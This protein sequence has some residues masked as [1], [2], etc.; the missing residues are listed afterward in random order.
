MFSGIDS[1]RIAKILTDL[2]INKTFRRRAGD[3]VLQQHVATRHTTLQRDAAQR[4][5]A[6]VLGFRDPAFTRF[7]EDEDH[8][9]TPSTPLEMS[10]PSFVAS[11]DETHT[12]YMQILEGAIREAVDNGKNKER[13]VVA[14]QR[15]STCRAMCANVPQV[16]TQ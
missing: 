9:E 1:P 10:A 4:G 3:Q 13:E 12:R 7:R 11:P 2:Q 8:S 6:Q 5:A 16:A 15:V 14:S